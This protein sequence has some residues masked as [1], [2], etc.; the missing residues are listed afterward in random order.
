MDAMYSVR[1]LAELQGWKGTVRG[2]C[3][4]VKHKY[5]AVAAK[6]VATA[7]KAATE[8]LNTA[9]CTNKM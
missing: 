8:R 2:L 4:L 7:V 9:S 6:D 5:V 3:S 1:K